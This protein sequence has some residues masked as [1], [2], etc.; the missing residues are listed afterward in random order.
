MQTLQKSLPAV[1]AV[2]LCLAATSPLRAQAGAFFTR[3]AASPQTQLT[4]EITNTGRNIGYSWSTSDDGPR[5]EGSGVLTATGGA[6]AYRTIADLPADRELLLALHVGHGI[7]QFSARGRDRQRRGTSHERL[8][9]VP[10]WGE[11]VWTSLRGIFRECVNLGPIAAQRGPVTRRLKDLAYA[12]YQAP[13]VEVDVSD[14]DRGGLLDISYAFAGATALDSDLSAWDVSRVTDMTG[15]FAQNSA[16]TADISRW[17]VSAV[18]S[19]REL[20]RDNPTYNPDLSAWDVSAVTDMS[21]AFDGAS[22]FDRDLSGWD[23]SSVRSMNAMFRRAVRF[24]QDLPDWDVS[25][26]RD[27]DRMFETAIAFN[28]DLTNWRLTSARRLARTF[29]STRDFRGDVSGWDV[30]TIEEFLGTF[31]SSGFDGDVSAWDM[32]SAT[33][34]AGM[35]DGAR[36]FGGDVSAWDVSSVTDMRFAFRR[37]VA[38][39]ADLSPWAPRLREGVDMEGFLSDSEYSCANYSRLLLALREEMRAGR[40]ASGSTLLGAEGLTY[41]SNASQAFSIT[42]R[43]FRSEDVSASALPC[44]HAYDPAD[45]VTIWQTGRDGELNFLLDRPANIRYYWETTDGNPYFSGEGLVSFEPDGPS[46]LRPEV[47]GLPI[48]REVALALESE[49]LEGFSFRSSRTPPYGYLGTSN[50]LYEVRQWGAAQ[51][52]TA[53][54][55]FRRAT[56]L[57]ITAADAPDLSLCTDLTS[58]FEGC[59]SLGDGTSVKPLPG[60][61]PPPPPGAPQEAVSASAAGFAGWDVS[62]VERLNSTFYQATDFSADLSAWD[63]S[64]VTD[65]NATFAGVDTIAWSLAAW[66][67]RLHPALDMAGFLD[68]AGMSCDQYS[69]LLRSLAD[70]SGGQPARTMGARGL[71]Y[72]TSAT[73]ARTTLVDGYGWTITGDAAA[74]E[75]CGVALPV[76]LRSFRVSATGGTHEL[77]WTTVTEVD[78]AAFVIEHAYGISGDFVPVGEVAGGGTT[79][80]GATYAFERREGRPGTHYYRLRQ[81]DFDGAE[82]LSEVVVVET[83]SGSGALQLYPNPAQDYVTVIGVEDGRSAQLYDVTG[84]PVA[85][86]VVEAG[87]LSLAGVPAGV[88]AVR[89]DGQ[90]DRPSVRLVVR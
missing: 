75:S 45:F 64:A 35:F 1:F 6:P 28:G 54:D 49:H 85:T 2:A 81:V 79:D 4:F 55:M 88:Y 80:A 73:A 63:V 11:I 25:Q 86:V 87:R 7:E 84:R 65:M 61:L 44:P 59:T 21:S 90:R 71:R 15:A 57:T 32:S 34:I 20:L 14:W 22:A 27:F 46:G 10:Q 8:I 42:Q 82:A 72:G 38:F 12:F 69:S 17:N 67:P 89:L 16:I 66:A 36:A 68:D 48:Y 33:S 19:L 50:L 76:T 47:S 60:A 26:V 58:M 31:A 9:G 77:S 43:H 83:G 18:T 3:W 37:T 70:N 29:G 51:W 74:N 5:L 24:N 53:V 56:N 23:V 40:F 39:D 62:G 78:N 52:R 30:S 41:G 13:N